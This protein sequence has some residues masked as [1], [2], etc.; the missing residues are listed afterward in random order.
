MGR[1]I[2]VEV[3][4]DGIATLI[5]D[6]QDKPMNVMTPAFNDEL[7]ETIE[8]VASDK[9]IAG[10]VITSAKDSFFAGADLKWLLTEFRYDLAAAEVLKKHSTVNRFLRRLET[11]G[12]PF[13]AAINGTALGGGLGNLPR[14]PS[15]R[16]RAQSK[17]S[18]GFTRSARGPAARR[19]RYPAIASHDRR[20]GRS[21][22]ARHRQAP[23]A[24]RSS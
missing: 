7:S 10:A 12:K 20:Q 19:R 11:C 17:V 18:P 16:G 4:G 8:R 9:A 15:S 5:I 2:R 22:V 3:G 24:R 21:G 1:Y 6:M 14:L 13:V 23:Y